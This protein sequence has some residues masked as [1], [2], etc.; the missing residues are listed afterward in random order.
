MSIANVDDPE[1][2]VTPEM[3]EAGVLEYYSEGYDSADEVVT[4]IFKAMVACCHR[5]GN[6]TATDGGRSRTT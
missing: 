5:E 1:I 4:R 3:I 2:E 6:G